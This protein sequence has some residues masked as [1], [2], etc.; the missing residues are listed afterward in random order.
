MINGHTIRG[1][2]LRFFAWMFCLDPQD[3]FP[4]A[5]DP[6]ERITSLEDA[7][8]KCHLWV[9]NE[10]TT[11][12]Q[13]VQLSEELH[14]AY[15]QTYR[16]QPQSLHFVVNNIDEIQTLEKDEV[17]RVIVPWMQREVQP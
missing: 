9:L 13:R 4:E 11:D 3:A 15:Y 1:W 12:E 10:D 17:R 6:L 2:I 7:P 16:R 8:D 5:L 14:D